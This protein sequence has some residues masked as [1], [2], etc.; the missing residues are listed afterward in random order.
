MRGRFSGNGLRP[1]C[2]LRSRAGFG[3]KRLAPCFRFYF[4][5]R[6]AGLFFRQ[7]FQLQITQRFAVR[8]QQLNAPLP[9]ALFQHPNLAS[10]FSIVSCAHCSS[11]LQR[12]DASLWIEDRHRGM[13]HITRTLENVPEHF[14]SAFAI[15]G[16]L[17][18]LLQIQPVHQHCQLFGSH[19]HSCASGAATRPMKPALLQPLRAHPQSAAIPHQRFQSGARAIGEQEQVSAQRILLPADRAPTRASPQI[20]CACRWPRWR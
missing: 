9:Q 2:G 11:R 19:R 3:G 5:A 10:R 20:L 14:S 1:G 12:R 8:T 18:R 17:L 16:A 7:Q 15:P 4:V 13:S 6:G